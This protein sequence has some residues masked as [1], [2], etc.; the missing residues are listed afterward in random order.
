MTPVAETSPV[1]G[2][3]PDAPTTPTN[4]LPPPPFEPTS[5][6]TARQ[7]PPPRPTL[8]PA[9]LPYTRVKV[10]SSNIR[11]N[12]KGKEVISFLIDVTVSVPPEA[13]PERKGGTAAWKIE[14]L[15]SEVLALDAGVKHKA[16]RA[17]SRGFAS[18]PDKSLFK[19]HAPHK[20]DQ[21]KVRPPLLLH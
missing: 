21:R 14:K 13:D 19:D 15:Y 5:N 2:L 7:G 18:L 12:E 11:T 3:Y 20:S 1:V 16:S 4:E 6:P 8:S 10:P 17:E 9:F